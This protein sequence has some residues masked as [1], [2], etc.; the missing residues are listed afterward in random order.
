MA[1]RTNAHL[2]S[3]LDA[4]S[5]FTNLVARLSVQAVAARLAI[6]LRQTR[7]TDTA[8]PSLLSTVLAGALRAL[9]V[10]RLR[11]NRAASRLRLHRP[12]SSIPWPHGDEEFTSLADVV[13]DALL[14]KTSSTN[15]NRLRVIHDTNY[16]NIRFLQKQHLNAIF[17][18]PFDYEPSFRTLKSGTVDDEFFSWA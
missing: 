14:Q 16:T 8:P 17:S 7:P 9:F 3:Q 13:F 18:K 1:P 12:F 6:D 11:P 10:A 5:V 4:L 15:H 2:L